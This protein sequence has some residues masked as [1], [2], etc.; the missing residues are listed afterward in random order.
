MIQYTD[1]SSMLFVQYFI[2]LSL[3]SL[4]MMFLIL[5]R[6]VLSIRKE[7]I[8]LSKDKIIDN[9]FVFGLGKTLSVLA[10]NL[11]DFVINY[12]FDKIKPHID[13]AIDIGAEIA[14]TVFAKIARK[15]IQLSNFI[16]GKRVL[17]N[18]GSTSLFLKNMGGYANTSTNMGRSRKE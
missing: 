17:K 14:H 13:S 1:M 2:A 6:K 5:Y 15:L 10:V 16:Q 12:F 9:S 8:I 11:W 7:E 3:V 18:R 4:L